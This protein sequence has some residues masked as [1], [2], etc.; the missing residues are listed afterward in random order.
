MNYLIIGHVEFEE[1]QWIHMTFNDL[2]PYGY[3]EK[4]FIQKVKDNDPDIGD[5]TVY[6]DFI[7]NS[8]KPMAIRNQS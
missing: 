8:Q 7:I 4:I 2:Q 6:I 5:K 1:Q 3:L